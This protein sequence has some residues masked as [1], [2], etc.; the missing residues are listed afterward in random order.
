MTFTLGGCPINWMSKLQ[1]IIVLLIIKAKYHT[2]SED[3]KEVIWLKR[4][5]IELQIG[6]DTPTKLYTNN[7]SNMKL[8]KN[9]I[10]HVKT[11]SIYIYIYINSK[12]HYI[13]K[14]VR[15]GT[16][17]INYIPTHEQIVDLLIKPLGRIHFKELQKIIGVVKGD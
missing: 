1:A 10:L 7:Q 8:I 13:R 11:R 16:I 3:A 14:K 6:D 4:L 17:K 12:H 15:D 9:L 5:F 2:L